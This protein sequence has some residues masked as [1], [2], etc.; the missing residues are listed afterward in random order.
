MQ[1]TC[2]SRVVG[3]CTK[4]PNVWEINKCY[5][6]VL[7][8][9]CSQIYI[10]TFFYFDVKNILILFENKKN[11]TFTETEA[12]H[13][14]FKLRSTLNNFLKTKDGENLHDSLKWTS[15]WAEVALQEPNLQGCWMW[16][17]L[18]VT[19]LVI[20]AYKAT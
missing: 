7:H 12:P 9:A 11:K 3:N 1:M 13:I 5:F 20:F 19:N 18:I 16:M 14:H 15:M 10:P 8:A 2:N 4:S 17:P 6:A